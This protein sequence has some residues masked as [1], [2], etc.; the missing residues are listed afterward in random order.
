MVLLASCQPI[1]FGDVE[2]VR[3]YFENDKRK[4][5]YWVTLALPHVDRSVNEIEDRGT[6][7]LW[8]NLGDSESLAVF[9]DEFRRE[10]D[11]LVDE[12]AIPNVFRLACAPKDPKYY[13]TDSFLCMPFNFST[14]AI[15]GLGEDYARQM[16]FFYP[17]TQAKLAD[18]GL[19]KANANEITLDFT[20]QCGLLESLRQHYFFALALGRGVVWN[21]T[22]TMRDV[23]T[24]ENCLLDHTH[25]AELDSALML[26]SK[27]AV[28]R[29]TLT[30]Q[31]QLEQSLTQYVDLINQNE[32]NW[33]I[34]EIRI[35]NAAETEIGIT[36]TTLNLTD[37]SVLPAIGSSSILSLFDD[38]YF[39]QHPSIS[40]EEAQP[41][42][43]E[44]AESRSWGTCLYLAIPCPN[45]G[46]LAFE[47]RITV[48]F[49]KS[50]S[51]DTFRLY[52]QCEPITLSEGRYYITS[53]IT[54]YPQL[55]ANLPVAKICQVQ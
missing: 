2:N 26:E 27:V 10:A 44:L 46:Q 4:I 19:P 23:V 39:L 9:G 14:Y 17:G 11:T 7:G 22:C 43:E 55:D 52:G 50:G 33:Y 8:F 45:E 28:V 13:M 38:R 47:P 54:C 53:N 32:S 6:E 21:T 31:A 37:G 1:H 20:R 49:S 48:L 24:G 34:S 40:A 16:A 36:R 30:A 12:E 5:D 29:L 15:H 3:N 18:G 35:E 42:P 41:L 25:N 51:R